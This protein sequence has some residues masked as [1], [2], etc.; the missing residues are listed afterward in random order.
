[1]AIPVI[2]WW[3]S[4]HTR[5]VSAPFDFLVV[6]AGNKSGKFTFNVWNNK[7][8][9]TDVSK[10]EDCTVTTRDMTG[11]LGNTLGAEVPLVRDNWMHVQV[12]SLAETD[13]N[14]VTSLVGKDYSKNIGTKGST[15]KNNL[16]ETLASPLTPLAKEI[17]G[18]QNNGTATDS[19]GNFT[20]LTF[21]AEVPLSASAGQQ[22]FKL[23]VNC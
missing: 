10:M 23:R 13:I 11:G 15:T 5:Q 17:L 12:D 19:A 3:D 16:G 18:V 8:G 2:S 14:D 20:T 22:N 4:T 1:M 7:G 6:D 9:A 21:Q